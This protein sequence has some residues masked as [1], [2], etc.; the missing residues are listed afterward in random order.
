MKKPKKRKVPKKY[1]AGLGASDKKQREEEL[2][3]RMKSKNPSYAPLSTD[4]DK[5]GKLRKTKT[6][7]HT[8]EYKKKFG[9][10][11]GTKK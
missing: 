11:N 5:S 1:T 2:R 10:K 7:K 4:F 6:S 8:T 9:G 3:S